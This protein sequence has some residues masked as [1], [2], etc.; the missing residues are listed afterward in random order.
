MSRISTQDFTEERFAMSRGYLSMQS[1]KD[2]FRRGQYHH[3]EG[4]VQVY[5]SITF[6]G[7]RTSLYLTRNGLA[8]SRNWQTAWGDRTISRLAREF[9]E[10]IINEQ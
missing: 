5:E 2:G 3:P 10:D 6:R 7:E 8:V 9:I 4:I 1:G